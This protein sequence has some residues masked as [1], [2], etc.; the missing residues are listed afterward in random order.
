MNS[1]FEVL[2]QVRNS[3]LIEIFASETWRGFLW[4]P[5]DRVKPR[6]LAYCFL[7]LVSGLVP[8]WTGIISCWCISYCIK[9]KNGEK[10]RSDE[11]DVTTQ[12]TNCNLEN[13]D[14]SGLSFNPFTHQ[15]WLLSGKNCYSFFFSLQNICQC[16][17]KCQPF[18][19]GQ[20]IQRPKPL[21]S[22]SCSVLLNNSF[23][24]SVYPLE[25]CFWAYAWRWYTKLSI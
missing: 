5:M 18:S 19:V 6:K 12:L 16:D 25:K 7:V 23:I 24:V 11:E 4:L 3:K 17:S 20:H 1:D 8:D 10:R 9:D 22:G 14:L 21:T 13:S 2:I 15:P